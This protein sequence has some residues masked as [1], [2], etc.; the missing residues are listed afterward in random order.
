MQNNTEDHQTPTI[1]TTGLIFADENPV[2]RVARCACGRSH[3]SQ[4]T[5]EQKHTRQL[6][7]IPCACG[8]VAIGALILNGARYNA[9]KPQFSQ[10]S[11]ANRI[12]IELLSELLGENAILKDFHPTSLTD[13]LNQ[14][15]ELSFAVVNHFISDRGGL[16]A[17][18]YWKSMKSGASRSSEPRVRLYKK[19][20]RRTF[21]GKITEALILHSGLTPGGQHCT[22]IPWL[23]EPVHVQI[24]GLIGNEPIEIFTKDR[25]DLQNLAECEISR[26]RG[27]LRRKLFQLGPQILATGAEAANLLIFE[28]PNNSKPLALGVCIDKKSILEFSK[29]SP[30]YRQTV[31]AKT[32]P[33]PT[34]RVAEVLRRELQDEPEMWVN[35]AKLGEKLRKEI[36]NFSLSGTGY[37]TFSSLIEDIEGITLRKSEGAAFARL[38]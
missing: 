25:L 6:P 18:T 30:R 10:T 22:Q 9:W 7:N 15:D 32:P 8:D 28:S 14:I 11:E 33:T 4:L 19:H 34:T 21:E 16:S 29:T 2:V 20:D 35:L 31:T 5:D 12:L 36:P 3:W 23:D 1:S 24:D 13:S 17:S 37:K 38:N 26:F 27:V